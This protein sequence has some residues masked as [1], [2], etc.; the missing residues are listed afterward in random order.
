M[1]VATLD[2][3][4]GFSLVEVIL[5]FFLVST[6]L[7]ITTMS[8][9]SSIDQEGP[10]G[11]AFTVASDL[12]SARAEAQRS[13]KMVAVCFASDGKTNSLSRSAFL[14]KGEQRGHLTRTL[15]YGNEY[16]A[17]IFLGTWPGSSL[18]THDLPVSWSVSTSDEVAIHF[19]PDGSAFSNDLPAID[20]NYPLVVGSSFTGT[21][22]GP[23]GT[24]TAV[25]NPQTVWVSAAGSVSVEERKVPGPDLP[26]GQSNLT[27]AELDPTKEPSPASPTIAELQ[28]LPE[29]I[30][31]MGTAYVG[32]NYVSIHPNQKDGNYLEYGI[33]TIEVK[34][35]DTDGGPLTYELKA[36]ASS[37]DDGKFT[38]SNLEG[39][40]KYLFDESLND[41]VWHSIISWRP[42]PGADPDLAYDLEI[43]V[44]DPEDNT[45]VVA[46]GA[47]L[48]PRVTSLPPSRIVVCTTNERLYL[49]NLDGSNEIHIN[50]DGK[51]HTP[52]F[53]ADGSRVFSFHDVSATQRQLRSRPAD[54]STAYD[55]LSTFAINSGA[56]FNGSSA[57]VKPDPTFTYAAVVSPAGNLSFPW[58]YVQTTTDPDTGTTDYTLV[59][60]TDPVNNA[61]EIAIINLMS[62][63]PPI[64]VTSAAT[65]AF[66]W[67][68]SPRYTFRYQEH[69][70]KPAVDVGHGFGFWP[71]PPGHEKKS[72][73]ARLDGY[74][75]TIVPTSN[76][77]SSAEKRIYNPAKPNWYL[78]VEGNDLWMRTD[79]SVGNVLRNERLYTSSSGYQND[80]VAKLTPTWSADGERVAFVANP[81]AA[82]K[83]V[84]M[85]TLS[86]TFVPLGSYSPDY[87][88]TAPNLSG[89][90]VSPSGRWAYYMRNQQ[91]FRTDNSTGSTPVNI[92]S[93]LSA[94]VTGYVL[95]P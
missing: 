46:S 50:K 47:G 20:G 38:V 9:R 35:Q 18:A 6:L 51:E 65:G 63:E 19:R 16:D 42:P 60:G 32:Q 75:P 64:T 30:P 90:Q 48:L 7:A 89:A 85:R 27:V 2:K 43:T 49:T 95:S 29:P 94:G 17:T 36:E 23:T 76:F 72:R 86:A 88:L 31:G 40:M 34:A 82:S 66:E 11:L 39:Q 79:D 62:N 93:H 13:G 1:G 45:V 69:V 26:V 44:R 71:P 55:L 80:H 10:R 21:F 74:P 54:G 3:K 58:G 87:E 25:T 41:Y 56:T 81:G 59:T 5:G 84:T 83:V 8:L 68:S 70:A 73:T 53:S 37:G 67:A 28:F 91:L 14:R 78:I 22:N 4:H 24:V 33:A 61:K 77:N 12:R 15:T 57:N 92:S 52:F